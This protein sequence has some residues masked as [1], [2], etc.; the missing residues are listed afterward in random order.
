MIED[1]ME[2]LFAVLMVSLCLPNYKSCMN[3][4]FLFKISI[5]SN[6]N[7]ICVTELLLLLLILNKFLERKFKFIFL[8]HYVTLLLFYLYVFFF[9][10]ES[11]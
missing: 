9:K 3:E 5:K 4:S 8:F 6:G 11:H 10:L 1:I 2:I 7:I